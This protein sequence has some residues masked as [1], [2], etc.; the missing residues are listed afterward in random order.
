M[1]FVAIVLLFTF[2]FLTFWV[3]FVVRVLGVS[4][5]CLLLVVLFGFVLLW[6]W[7][8]SCFGFVGF[9]TWVC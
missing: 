1:V 6:I 4:F 2:G 3:C 5:G 7:C 9:L 8:F